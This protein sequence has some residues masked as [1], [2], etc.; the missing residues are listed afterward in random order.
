[1]ESNDPPAPIVN[2]KCKIDTSEIFI[3]LVTIQV[4]VVVAITETWI[5]M[6]SLDHADVNSAEAW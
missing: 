6:Q 4:P 1:M 3:D 5:T 2:G